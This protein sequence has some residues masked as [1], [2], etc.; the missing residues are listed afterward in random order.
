MSDT[1]TLR[2]SRNYVIE[3]TQALVRIDSVNPDLEP[4][5]AGEGEV[6][7]Y[8]AAELERLGVT[9][10]LQPVED[11]RP[12]VIGVIEGTGGGRSLMLNAHTD[13]V[14]V[15]GMDA[16]FGGDLRDGRVYGRGTYDM[17]GSLAAMLG[18]VK[19][20]QESDVTLAGDLLFTAVVDEEYGSKGAEALVHEYHADAVVLTE[21]TNLRV[22]VA[23][24]GF[25]WL[26]VL[27]HGRAAHGSRPHEGVD[28]NAHM[29]RVLVEVEKLGRDLLAREGHPLLG[30]PSIHIPL[31][32]GGTSQSVYAAQARAELERRTLPG[33]TTADVQAEVAAIIERLAA[34][35]PDFNA[36]V[37]AF[38]DRPPYEIDPEA[39]IVEATAGAVQAVTGTAP[40]RYGEG[41]WMD[42]AIFAGAGMD[43]VVLGPTGDGLHTVEEWVTVDSLA[44]LAAALAQTAVDWCGVGSR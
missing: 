1:S 27:T 28:A 30:P 20:L 22:C 35:D 14:G 16:P 5:A 39:A 34:D 4:G 21:P 12:N 19:A 32:S 38:F 6:A 26:E 11:G 2:I 36:E 18:V 41:W 9:A 3:Q 44:T 31:L 10:T 17:K 29:A 37:R 8:L 24:R 33:E 25:V 40:E 15:T 43:T 42:S 7:A 13:T 23:H